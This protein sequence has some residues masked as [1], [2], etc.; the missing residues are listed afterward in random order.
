MPTGVL[1]ERRVDAVYQVVESQADSADDEVSFDLRGLQSIRPGALTAL[2][3]HAVD[4]THSGHRVRVKM[5][6]NAD[7]C[8]YLETVSGFCWYLEN[9]DVRFEGKRCS[10]DFTYEM[11]DTILSMTTVSIADV[12]RVTEEL[13]Q[14]F[15]RTGTMQSNVLLDEIFEGFW[16]PAD[17][18]IE[19]SKSEVGVVCLA[20]TWRT[21]NGRFAEVAVADTGVGIL[22]TL[23]RR[24]P[25]LGSHEEAIRKALQEGVSGLDD[26]ERGLGLTKAHDVS[27]AGVDRR[28][29]I[30]SGNG[31]VVATPAGTSFATLSKSWSGTL[32]SLLFPLSR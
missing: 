18:A 8:E 7:C 31:R 23:K 22:A 4:V 24:Y 11:N 21:R 30:V 1:L 29:M 16:E 3:A 20:Q 25:D 14:G 2:A 19:H 17:N 6:D 10:G 26:P 12:A 15:D 9:L 5:P 32:V 27:K 13:Y 28:L